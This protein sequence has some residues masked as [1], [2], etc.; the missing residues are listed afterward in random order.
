MLISFSGIALWK[1]PN[2]PL[3]VWVMLD[4]ILRTELSAFFHQVLPLLAAKNEEIVGVGVLHIVL[5]ATV[6]IN[7]NGTVGFQTAVL[8]AETSD[9][10][11]EPGS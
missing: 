1:A 3:F 10:H 6:I 11:M 8:N 5:V 9:L 7:A 4:I 2:V